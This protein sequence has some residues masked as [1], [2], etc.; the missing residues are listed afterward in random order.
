MLIPYNVDRP[1]RKMPWVTYT[2]IGINIFV[3][4]LTVLIANVD[5]PS[6]QLLAR[7]FQ[8]QLLQKELSPDSQ[9][10]QLV[11]AISAVYPNLL[12]PPQQLPGD[13]TAGGDDSVAPTVTAQQQYMQQQVRAQLTPEDAQQT[14]L[15][16][17]LQM[18][19]QQVDTPGGYDRLWQIQH[20]NDRV[21]WEPRYSTLDWMAYHPNEP[22]PWRKLLGL[23][24]SMFLHGG[25]MHVLGN[26]F[27][28]WIFGR[29]VEDALGWPAYLGAYLLCGFAAA[30]MQHIMTLIFSPASMGVPMLGASGAIAG[31][32][33]LFAPRFYRTPVRTF[34]V[35]PYAIPLVL[36]GG[37]ILSLIFYTVLGDYPTSIF[38]GIVLALVGMYFWGR[39]WCWGIF[40]AP[41]AWW[42]A[43]YIIAFNVVPGLWGLRDA[44][45]GD[46]VAH[47][48]HIGGF[49]VGMLYAF[50]IGSPHEGR[51]EFGL[52]DAEKF[53][54][55]GDHQH[56]IKHAQDLV[57]T[58]A[59]EAPAHEVLGKSLA[60]QGKQEESLD[61][62]K[63]AI[64]LYLRKG[65]RI[66]AARAYLVASSYFPKFALSPAQQLAVGSIMESEGDY[67]NAVLALH[68][69]FETS[70]DAPE[71]EMALLRCARIYLDHL[72]R[73]REA[74]PLLTAFAKQYPQSQWVGQAR[75][76]TAQAENMAQSTRENA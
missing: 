64:V 5:L 74:L 50:L 48:A 45:G 22:S 59:Q 75:K 47:W 57:Q 26:M 63:K 36:I 72:G 24:G 21:V 27:F 34:Y 23:I 2:L 53:Y 7:Q 62:F 70:L 67:K 31:V 71:T 52:E 38:L 51:S 8:I 58:A 17:T 18:A 1:A 10:G 30:L 16:I 9:Q 20:M 61:Y 4:L 56:A 29:A 49:G 6:D 15:D 68:K 42:L 46:G 12:P 44:A 69:I 73:P 76:L 60:A 3:F 66:Q 25:I 11:S 40:K 37:G 14:L 43:F 32:L 55:E 65:E 35:L 19:E 28:L 13:A 54:A 41:A 39:T 33:G